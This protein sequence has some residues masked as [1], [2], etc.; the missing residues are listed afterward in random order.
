MTLAAR[1]SLISFNSNSTLT[2]VSVSK[3]SVV[4]KKIPPSEKFVTVPVASLSPAVILTIESIIYLG[5]A[6][7]HLTFGS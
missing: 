5:F 2:T 7:H 1:F 6:S 4:F 3:S